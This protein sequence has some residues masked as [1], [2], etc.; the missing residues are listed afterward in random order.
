MVYMRCTGHEISRAVYGDVRVGTCEECPEVRFGL[1]AGGD[2]PWQALSTLFGNYVLVG[3][4]DTI[5]APAG[6]VLAYRS[7]RPE[8]V[9]PLRVT[10][11]HRWL[12]VTGHLWMCHDGSH[13][14]LAHESPRVSRMVGA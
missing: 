4:V 10:P 5:R 1:G 14:L 6:E 12:K 2:D 13:L 11:P 9:A 3:R 8:G 7:R